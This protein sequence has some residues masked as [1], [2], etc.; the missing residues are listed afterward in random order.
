M[1]CEP[2]FSIR[3]HVFVKNALFQPH[4]WTAEACLK[5]TVPWHMQGPSPQLA[6]GALGSTSAAFSRDSL[7]TLL[8]SIDFLWFSLLEWEILAEIEQNVTSLFFVNSLFVKSDGEANQGFLD[9]Y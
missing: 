9:K 3:C 4:R 5:S 1:H 8:L 2:F 6:Q 7:A